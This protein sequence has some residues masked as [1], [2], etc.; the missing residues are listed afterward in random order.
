MMHHINASFNDSQM[1]RLNEISSCLGINRQAVIRMLLT[2]YC[3]QVIG[4]DDDDDDSA[5]DDENYWLRYKKDSAQPS[6]Y[7]DTI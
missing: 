6:L 4:D 5:D 1:K 3:E 2:Y 7:C